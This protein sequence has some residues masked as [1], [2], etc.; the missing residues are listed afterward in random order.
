MGDANL[1]LGGTAIKPVAKEDHKHKL[2]T[3]FIFTIMCILLED[4]VLHFI[5]FMKRAQAGWDRTGWEAFRYMIYD[6]EN[7]TILTRFLRKVQTKET[8]PSRTP[9][10]GLR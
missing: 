6:G 3:I 7:G 4:F 10:P 2:F 9:F 8:S 5:V 1:P